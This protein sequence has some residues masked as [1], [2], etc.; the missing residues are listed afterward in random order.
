LFEPRAS[1]IKSRLPDIS[2]IIPGG[3]HCF[4]GSQFAVLFAK[5]D[6]ILGGWFSRSRY[7]EKMSD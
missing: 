3:I 5:V 1:E 6:T 2:M 7:F 4:R